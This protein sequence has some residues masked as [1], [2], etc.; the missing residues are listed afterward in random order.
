MVHGRNDVHGYNLHKR[1]ALSLNCLAELLGKDDE[2]LFVDWNTADE[3]PTFPEAIADTFTPACRALLRVLRVRPRQHR[4]LARL[5]HLPVLDAPARNVAIR[6]ADPRNKWL[7]STTTDIVLIPREPGVKLS[8]VIAPLEPA[9]YHLPRF[10]VPEGLWEALDR[11]DPIGAIA[12]C[13]HWGSRLHLNEIVE[14]DPAVKYEAPGDFQLIPMA[15]ARQLCGFDER[16]LFTY[17]M[18]S[19][20]AKRAGLLLGP[21]RSLFDQLRLYHCNHYRQNSVHHDSRRAE[22][23]WRRF[24]AEVDRPSLPEQADSWGLADETV[25]EIALAPPGKSSL[26]EALTGAIPKPAH[27]HWTVHNPADRFNSLDYRPEHVLP[28]LADL[29]SNLPRSAEIG[30]FAT[31]TALLRGIVETC[32]ALGFSQPILVTDPE[33]PALS[34]AKQEP[35][36]A[37]LDRAATLIFEF[38]SEEPGTSPAD[39]NL[40]LR[41][42]EVAAAFHR[43]VARERERASQGQAPRQHFIVVN[44]INTVFERLVSNHLVFNYTPFTL[45]LRHGV[46]SIAADPLATDLLSLSAWLA[47]R[48]GRPTPVP[49]SELVELLD[50]L[51]ANSGGSLPRV[52]EPLLALLDHPRLSDALGIEPKAWQGRV[53]AI[54]RVPRNA[55]RI[56]PCLRVRTNTD[57]RSP[58]ALSKFADIEDWNRAEWLEQLRLCDEAAQSTNFLQRHRSTWEIGQLLYAA[59]MAAP[60]QQTGR[61]RLILNAQDSFAV[62][63]ARQYDAIEILAAPGACADAGQKLWPHPELPHPPARVT[64]L[65]GAADDLRAYDPADL[66]VLPQNAVLAA[67]LAG[68]APTLECL[69]AMLPV[70]GTLLF[71][72]EIVV[73]GPAAT[74]RLPAQ[75]AAGGRLQQLVSECTSW[76]PAGDS[77]WSLGEA[78]LDRLAVAG[79]PSER[80]PHFVIQIGD[81]WSTTGVWA[82]RKTAATPLEGWARLHERLAHFLTPG[83]DSSASGT[84]GGKTPGSDAPRQRGWF[85]RGARRQ[86]RVMLGG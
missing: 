78:T 73:A 2:I 69:D 77:D 79:T 43:A 64:I 71:A 29:I 47:Q 9:L 82:W 62:Y 83:G 13:A 40:S 58:T 60:P 50:L 54:R 81:L 10:D 33:L 52:S 80:E 42:G 41:L 27:E 30:F 32:H 85:G 63:V 45:R 7:L 20:F 35:E 37:I 18:D 15:V 51:A 53:E 76:T 75:L 12:L 4:R 39:L 11:R 67:G 24:V 84:L 36:A 46:V 21:V 6:R 74:D 59:S 86:L 70:G 19:N 1:A 23:S 48:T 8:D 56:D 22:N 16:M 31:T 49:L 61:V 65:R 5:T 38:G 14:G 25:E 72:A 57:R 28:F 34:G 68:F 66:I 3:L 17:H 26:A 55:A 44:A